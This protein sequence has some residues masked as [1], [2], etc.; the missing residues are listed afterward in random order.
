M[1]TLVL[2]RLVC[3]QVSTHFVYGVTV[4]AAVC[5]SGSNADPRV[6]FCDIS[7]CENVGLYITDHAEVRSCLVTLHL[8][9]H[10]RLAERCLLALVCIILVL[11]M[12]WLLFCRVCSKIMRSV[13]T[14]WPECGWKTMPIQSCDGIT[15]ITAGTSAS[16][17]LI[18][19]WWEGCE[20]KGIEPCSSI[21]K[22]FLGRHFILQIINVSGLFW[23]QQ[24]PQQSDSWLWGEG[25]SKPIGRQV[26]DSPRPDGWHLCSWEWTWSIYRQ[27]DSF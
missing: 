25:R 17:L 14:P 19:A 23:K 2:T 21:L 8:F 10:S 24:Y 18:M 4:G 6:R 1:W 5:V 7:D 20:I 27:Q 22:S 16:S 13:E 9:L 12:H 26:R 15:F 11:T 3:I